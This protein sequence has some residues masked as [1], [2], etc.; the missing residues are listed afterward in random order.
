[1]T[2]PSRPLPVT[3]A[4]LVT[5]SIGG[6]QFAIDIMSVREIRG[7]SRSTPLPN[8]PAHFL[9]MINL[10]GSILPVVDLRARLGLGVSEVGRASVVIVVQIGPR[11]VGLLVDAVC[12][13]LRVTDGMIQ[14]PPDLGNGRTHEFVHGVMT[15]DDAVVSLLYLDNIAPATEEAAVAA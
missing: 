3:G 15:M 8:A 13:I 1:M 7:W 10:R 4:E 14:A 5:V 12:D 6:Q 9:G 11:Q 2:E